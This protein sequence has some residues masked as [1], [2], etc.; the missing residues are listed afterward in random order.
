MDLLNID[1]NNKEQIQEVAPKLT[2][3]EIAELV[4]MLESKDDQ[5]RYRAF[6]LLQT[7]SSFDN[8]CYKY[9]DVFAS[10]LDNDNSYQRSIGLMML[11]VNTKWDT[12]NKFDKIVDKYLE[13]TNDEK[14]ITA[15]QTIQALKDIIPY[16]SNLID[17]IKH[18]L[19]N[20]DYTK[21]KV[22]Q[23]SLIDRDIDSVMKL[24]VSAFE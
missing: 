24:I 12:E 7:R 19:N 17:T 15:R 8:A 20:I 9:F 11:A 22:N 14:F 23:K 6:L 18:K 16:K 21:Y 3:Q 4:P 5:L 13:H 10:K 1:T 2:E